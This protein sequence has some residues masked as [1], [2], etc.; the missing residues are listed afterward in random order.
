MKKSPIY[1]VMF[2]IIIISSFIVILL[3]NNGEK[4]ITINVNCSRCYIRMFRCMNVV[5]AICSILYMKII[6]AL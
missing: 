6:N 3:Q 5:E 1:N 4:L 2:F